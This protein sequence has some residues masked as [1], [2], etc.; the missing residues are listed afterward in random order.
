MKRN[1]TFGWVLALAT[2]L[3]ILD[4]RAEPVHPILKGSSSPDV[5]VLEEHR[6]EKYVEL[7]RVSVK[8]SVSG[9]SGSGTICHYDPSTG[10]AHVISCGH[11]WSGNRD[12]NPSSKSSAKV[13]VWYQDGKRLE[14]PKTYDAEALFWSNSRGHDVSLLRFRPDWDAKYAPIAPSFSHERGFV[15]N[16]MGC[17]GGRE[18]ARYEVR[19]DSY[20][21]P[22]IRTSLNSPR[23]GRSGGGLLTDDG[24][25][26]GICWGTSDVSSGDGTGFFT[27]LGSIRT[28]FERNGHGWLLDFAWD[29]RKI[30][31]FDHD[32]PGRKYERHFV[33]VPFR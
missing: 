20:S 4:L 30:P 24:T 2:A 16:S 15:L 23:P 28:V 3:P 26:V 33:P 9:G 7:L 12:Y 11:L 1:S 6:N 32:Q 25:L 8:V 17:D 27:P 14:S 29:A 5:C 10:W 31:V 21:H 19:I 13:T 22:D 18:V